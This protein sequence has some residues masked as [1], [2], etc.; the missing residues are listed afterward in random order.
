MGK[1]IKSKLFVVMIAFGVNIKATAQGLSGLNEGMEYFLY[2]SIGFIIIAFSFAIYFLRLKIKY[3]RDT[4]RLLIQPG[5][6]KWWKGA[7]YITAITVIVFTFGFQF[8]RTDP[9]AINP[10][11]KEENFKK[12]SDQAIDENTITLSDAKGIAEGK[13][14]FIGT[15]FACHGTNGEGNAVGPNLTDTYWLHGGSIKDVFKTITN[16]VPDKGM[17]PWG[18]TY[19][20]TEIR[21]LSSFIL[22]L[23]GTNPA[24]AKAPQGNLYE[25]GKIADHA[26]LKNSLRASK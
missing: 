18:K 15:C 25:P 16:G 10:G 9:A 8:F 22:S 7:F 5:F 13:K 12:N 11:A 6:N 21:N 4:G 19:S 24:N 17:Q 23:Q 14:I 26:A 2:G 3:Q 1:N 20:P